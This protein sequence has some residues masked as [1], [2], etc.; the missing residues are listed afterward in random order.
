MDNLYTHNIIP[1]ILEK[2][3]VEI[4]K[5]LNIIKTF[6]KKV[7]IDF[8]DGKFFSNTTLMDPTPFSAFAKELFLEA[9]L[10]VEEPIMYLDK[11]FSAGFK[12]FL[13]HIEMMGSQEEF[14][15]KGELLG[16]VGLAVDLDTP[17][18][19]I[20]VPMED[21]DSLLL[22]SIKAGESGQA[23]EERVVDKIRQARSQTF[24]PIEVDGGINDQT[25]PKCKEAGASNFVSTSFIFNSQ[26]PA[27]EYQKLK[28]LL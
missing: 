7:H 1:G 11:L 22:M 12:K 27:L 3:W 24:I 16:E 9:H 17:L 2:D 14:V 5:K 10:M 13:G 21:I 19:K 20:S 8:I 25:L 18:E 15:A 28:D 4:E 6:S 23:F 26:N